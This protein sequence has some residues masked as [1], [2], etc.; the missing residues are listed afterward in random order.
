MVCYY[1]SS[2]SKQ[3]YKNIL[4]KLPK[5]NRKSTTLYKNPKKEQ[6]LCVSTQY[7]SMPYKFGIPVFE[8]KT[9]GLNLK[10]SLNLK[11]RTHSDLQIKVILI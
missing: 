11:R 5:K 1:S 8:L 3:G 6:Y 4:A 9:I 7:S 10:I 2:T